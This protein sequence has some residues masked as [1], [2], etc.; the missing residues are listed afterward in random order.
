MMTC[1]TFLLIFELPEGMRWLGAASPTEAVGDIPL[2]GGS[3]AARPGESRS[4]SPA[5]LSTKL[6]EITKT[7]TG[8]A[9]AFGPCPLVPGTYSC[10]RCFCASSHPT[11]A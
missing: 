2:M 11:Y 6:A 4:R 9:A 7:A 3:R 10:G 8:V 1:A 5:Q